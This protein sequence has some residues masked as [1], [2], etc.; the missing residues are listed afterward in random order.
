MDTCTSGGFSGRI[1][2]N[3]F[4]KNVLAQFALN[5]DT[6]LRTLGIWHPPVR[7]V[8]RPRSTGILESL[9]D[10]FCA[11]PRS[12]FFLR[13]KGLR[14]LRS[15][16]SRCSPVKSGH[17]S[18]GHC[19]WHS[20]VSR[21]WQLEEFQQFLREGALGAGGDFW[22]TFRIQRSAWS[23]G[24]YKSRQSTVAFGRICRF[25]FVKVH[26]GS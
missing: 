4:V 9:G 12:T 11:R 25:F 10:G 6:I 8:S 3:F 22:K 26:S 23:H 1:P 7:C 14:T 5:L 17:F 20:C 18:T 21:R 13:E 16:F 24:R 15:D 19:I 2:H